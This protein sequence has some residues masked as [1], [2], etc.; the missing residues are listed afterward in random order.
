F[1]VHGFPVGLVQCESNFLGIEHSKKGTTIGS[2]GWLNIT[3][4]YT[5]A[6]AYCTAP[7]EIMGNGKH[8]VQVPVAGEWIGDRRTVSGRIEQRH[9][10]LRCDSATTAQIAP[11]SLDAVLTDPPYFGNVQYAELM[12][13]CYVVATKF[14]EH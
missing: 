3:E 1:S 9:V 14:L 7:F 11:A 5:K 4:K 12:D 8:K 2:G 6:K 10:I 13:F